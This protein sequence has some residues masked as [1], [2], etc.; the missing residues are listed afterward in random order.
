MNTC[1]TC[2][3]WEYEPGVY[4]SARRLLGQCSHAAVWFD[5]TEWTDEGEDAI[6]PE[7]DSMTMF[8]NDGSSYYAELLTRPN[9]GCVSWE[10]K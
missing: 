9:H 4:I 2:K 3:F 7:F 6:K 5:A 1:D 8:V 10:G